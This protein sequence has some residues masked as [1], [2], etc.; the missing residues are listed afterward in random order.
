M[1]AIL[2]PTSQW[3]DSQRGANTGSGGAPAR[4]GVDVVDAA[5]RF[6][7]GG[8]SKLDGWMGGGF[9]PEASP[10]LPPV[11]A[12]TVATNSVPG[13][14]GGLIPRPTSTV[15]PGPA[16][17]AAVRRSALFGSFKRAQSQSAQLQQ[18]EQTVASGFGPAPRQGA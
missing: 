15:A 6:A 18:A 8:I 17:A 7:Q 3:L 12:T 10:A 16:G 4:A 11:T 9:H 5:T 1:S 13:R 14:F 2:Y